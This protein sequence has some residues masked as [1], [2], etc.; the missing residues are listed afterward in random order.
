MKS[1]ENQKA[2]ALKYVTA[3]VMTLAGCVCSVV[4]FIMATVLIKN[5]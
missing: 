2:S 1:L 5:D 4:S 3:I